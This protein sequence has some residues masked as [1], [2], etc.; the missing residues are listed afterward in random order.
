MTASSG[1]GPRFGAVRPRLLISAAHK[2]SGKTTFTTGLA[3]ALTARGLVV[4][5]YKKGPDYIDPLWHMRATRR[6]CYNLDFNTQD[7][8]E[9]EATIAAHGEG[10]DFELI[11]GNKGLHDGVDLEGR[12]STAA[13]AK[14]VGAPV[15]LVLDAFGMTRGIAPLVMGYQVFDREVDIRGIVLNRVATARQETKLRQALERYTDLRVLGCIGRSADLAVAERHL[16]L[17][18]PQETD[19]VEM[20]VSHL[21]ETVAADVDI[22]A[23]I[24]IARRP[25]HGHRPNVTAN[26]VTRPAAAAEAEPVTIG[27]VRDAA[28][29]FYY[30]DDLEALERAGARLTYFSALDTPRL[31]RIDGLFIGGGFPESHIGR[32]AANASLRR[33]I[34]RAAGEGLPIYA[35]CGGLMY[36]ARSIAWKGEVGEMVGVVP[37]DAVVQD[38]PQGRGLVV[39]EETAAM[40]WPAPADTGSPLRVKAHEFHYARLENLEPGCRFAYRVVRGDGITGTDDGIVVANTMASFTHLRDTSRARWAERFVAFVRARAAAARS[41]PTGLAPTGGAWAGRSL[42][43]AAAA[44]MRGEDR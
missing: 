35:E 16:G 2:S 38:R 12:D 15:V 26:V 37:G 18:T 34:A 14:L 43:G 29:C 7:P 8:S 9:I 11:E 41:K 19:N 24:E 10:V 30:Q 3:A 36:L 28:F 22:D 23:V 33:D 44:V 40:P 42:S 20:I 1:P 17:T 31:P 25:A 13:L 39:M 32:L 5:T 27:V 4:Q 21:A 6:P